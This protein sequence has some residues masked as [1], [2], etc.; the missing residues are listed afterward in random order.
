[1]RITEEEL[2]TTWRYFQYCCL[3]AITMAHYAYLDSID[4]IKQD[5]MFYRHET[6]QAINRIGKYLEA[7]PN[8]LMDVSQHNVRYMNILGDNIEEQFEEETKELQKGIFLSFK[9][10]KMKHVECLTALHYTSVMLQIASA[11]FTSC[12][13]DMKLIL[14]KDPTELFHTYNLHDVT[15]RW[16]SIVD[17]ASEV[18]GYNKVSKKTPS[19]DL[20][21]PRC[22]MAIDA[23]RKKYADIETLRIAMKKSYPW[24]LNYQEGVPYEESIDYQIVNT[25]EK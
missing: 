7:L 11:I 6:K 13:E 24:S 14:H 19:V 18:F 8:R 17:K 9:N 22:M 21:N 4:N 16:S 5:K 2:I 15:A 1:M 12:C 23:I 25:K 3:P 10:A 20:N